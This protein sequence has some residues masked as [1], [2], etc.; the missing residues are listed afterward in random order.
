[1]TI[2]NGTKKIEAPSKGISCAFY[3]RSFVGRIFLRIGFSFVRA[4]DSM[5]LWCELLFTRLLLAS[6]LLE[7]SFSWC[8]SLLG[9]F[10]NRSALLL[11]VFI[12]IFFVSYFH[13]AFVW[14][15]VYYMCMRLIKFSVELNIFCI[16]CFFHA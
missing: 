14:F 12:F 9:I 2:N 1:M 10:H 13:F 7:K 8:Q 11:I 5:I 16:C 3:V 4:R 15:T 6:L